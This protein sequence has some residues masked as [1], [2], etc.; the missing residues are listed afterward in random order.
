MTDL[1]HTPTTAT[2]FDAIRRVDPDGTEWWSARD[3]MPLLGY[4]K[5]ERFEDA[6]DRAQASASATGHDTD[7]AFSRLR[8]KGAGRPSFDYRL[9][10]YAAYLTAMNGDPRK[11]EIAAA[12]SYFAVRT[13]QAEV[14]D[15]LD[16][17]EVA[18]RYVRAIED[19]RAAVARAEA[20]ETK[21]AIAAPKAEYVDGFVTPD[22]DSSI[23]RVFAAQ[24]GV[25][26]KA[27]RAWLVD[28]KVIY[29]RAVGQRWSNSQH[30][31]VTEYQW[32]VY[33][34]YQSWFRPVDQPNAPRLHNGQM[35][36]TLYVLPVGKVAIRRLLMKHPIDGE[37]AA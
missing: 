28:R 3:L 14:R 29:R 33:A 25:G 27:L 21:L 4:T 19:K 30:R 37:A 2:P 13:R 18:R 7:Q 24:L 15:E 31:L 22:E 32:L 5:W 34:D 9:T 26:E 1:A 35:A 16:E 36:T 23:L 11:P 12:Q 10:R 17:L 20:A 6:I 8:E